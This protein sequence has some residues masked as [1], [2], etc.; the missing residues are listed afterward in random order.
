MLA[1]YDEY[2]AACAKVA[3]LNYQGLSL[4]DLL[5]LQSR[6]EHQLRCAPAVDHAILAEIQTRTTPAEMG[7]KSWADVLVGVRVA[8][9]A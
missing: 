1:A 6:R 8:V 4:P 3:A 9:P 7:A 5:E 2:D